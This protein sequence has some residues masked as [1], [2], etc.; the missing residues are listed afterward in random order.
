MFKINSTYFQVGRLFS[1]SQSWP[2]PS[3]VYTH[4]WSFQQQK[5]VF[6]RIP[7]LR[8]VYEFMSQS[9]TVQTYN[10]ALCVRY[11]NSFNHNVFQNSQ[12]KIKPVLSHPCAQHEYICR[13]SQGT[14]DTRKRK[15]S[16]VYKNTARNRQFKITGNRINLFVHFPNA[17]EITHTNVPI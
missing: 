8:R 5:V 11:L 2:V 4:C 17:C 14:D 16:L 10:L 13:T 7:I 1:T 3:P 6:A 15:L 12:T 9:C